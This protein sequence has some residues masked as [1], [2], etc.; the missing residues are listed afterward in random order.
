MN[1]G[2]DVSAVVYGTGVSDYTINLVKHLQLNS[3][4]KITLFGTSFRRGGEITN[5]FPDAHVIP[6]P[7]T[8]ADWM[9]NKWHLLSPEKWTGPLDVLHSSDWTQPPAKAKKVTTVHDLS[10]FLYPHET[11]PQIVEVHTRRMS[12]VVKECD[13]II[14]VSSNTAADLQRLFQVPDTKIKIIYEAL[15][16][17]FILKPRLTKYTNYL[18]AIGARQ[19]RKNT[20]RL[21]SAFTS[22]KDKLSLPPKLIIIGENPGVSSESV[23]YMG[24]VTDQDLVDLLAGASAFV[25]PSLYEGFGLPIL[26]AFYHKVPVV[27]SNTSSI[28]EVAGEAA[29]LVDPTSEE[30]IA[31]GIAQAIQKRDALVEAGTKQLAKFSWDQTA[32]ETLNVYRSL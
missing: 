13:A 22:F 16:E 19:P 18:L 24:Q 15:P 11:N 17:R 25:Y 26:G 31:Q 20:A 28:P 1:I 12:W 30:E 27:A 5:I 6:L 2:I 3:H 8:V 10:P 21:V 29:I 4:E 9:W 7:P 32:Q 23:I 14:C